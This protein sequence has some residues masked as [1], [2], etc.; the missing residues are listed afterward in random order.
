MSESNGMRVP[1]L[2]QASCKHP[3]ASAHPDK[4]HQAEGKLTR[5]YYAD[6]NLS[7]TGTIAQTIACFC[8]KCTAVLIPTA[9]AQQVLSR[10]EVFLETIPIG[11]IFSSVR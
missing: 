10:T 5:S 8:A 3:V 4:P 9:N 7:F 2:C 1:S 6:H 11:A